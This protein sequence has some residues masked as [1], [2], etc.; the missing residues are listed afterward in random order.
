VS[1]KFRGNRAHVPEPQFKE[2]PHPLYSTFGKRHF[3]KKLSDNYEWK[4]SIRV[5]PLKDQPK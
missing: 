2:T 1:Q 3:D 5:D 4:P